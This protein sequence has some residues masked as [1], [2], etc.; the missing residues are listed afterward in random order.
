MNGKDA[1]GSN[2]ALKAGV[3]YVI[4]SIM[5]KMV[6]VIT[7]PVFTRALTTDEYGTVAT[8]SS[9]YALLNTVYNLNL[10]ISIGRAKLDYPDKID[11]YIGSM[12]LLSLLVSAVLSAVILVFIVPIASFFELTVFQTVLLLFYLMSGP[13]VNFYQNGCKYK[14]KYKQNIGIA[15]Y[16]MVSTVA[17]SLALIF[18]LPGDKAT[19]RIMGIVIPNFLLAFILCFRA[20]RDGNLKVNMEFWKYGLMISLPMILHTVSMNLLAQSDRVVISKYYGATQVAFYSLTRNYALLLA[21]VTEAINQAWQPWFHDSLKEGRENLIKANSRQLVVLICYIGLASIA[22]SPEAVLLLGGK[23][24]MEAVDCVP[25]MVLGV[26]CQCI[27]TNYINVEIHMKKTQYAS[28]G[29]MIAAV[30]NII[31][32]LI[33]VP[34]YGYAAAAYTTFASYL[35]LLVLHYIVSQRLLKVSIYDNRFFLTAMLGTAA[36]SVA[37]RMTFAHTLLRGLLIAMGFLSFLFIFR[38]K[39]FAYYCKIRN[40]E[41]EGRQDG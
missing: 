22:I 2:L 11:H 38:R 21:V 17:L 25:P 14:Y 36:V 23:Q 29:T 1:T 7:T 37:V 3:W 15:W 33:F 30:L 5:V 16:V 8:F 18:I 34:L 39:V 26:V 10:Y 6:S 20:W 13:T 12:Q 4:S 9:W 28:I 27:Y 40:T 35:V 24:Y 31:L 19:L 41:K 32:N